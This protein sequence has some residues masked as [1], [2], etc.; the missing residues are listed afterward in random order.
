[1]LCRISCVSLLTAISALI[2][3]GI[4][5]TSAE[6]PGGYAIM[7]ATGSDMDGMFTDSYPDMHENSMSLMS[8]NDKIKPGKTIHVIKNIAKFTTRLVIDLSWT[9]KNTDLNI[10]VYSPTSGNNGTF[11]DNIDG[12]ID[13][14]IIK[15]IYDSDGLEYGVWDYF[16][17]N[18]G[19][20]E[21]N[22]SV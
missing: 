14:R 2:V 11:Y 6:T 18:I 17:K 20:E 8:I 5:G 22:F 13:Q 21:T 12:K 4:A 15:D 10:M 3:I 16:I 9:N 7:P 19:R 1:M